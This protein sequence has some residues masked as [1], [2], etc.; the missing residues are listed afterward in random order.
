MQVPLHYLQLPR[1][2][3]IPNHTTCSP[4]T[5]PVPRAKTKNVQKYFIT[6]HNYRMR[7]TIFDAMSF[8]RRTPSYIAF[9][10]SVLLV[11]QFCPLHVYTT[12]I[13]ERTAATRDDEED[14]AVEEIAADDLII[15]CFVLVTTFQTLLYTLLG[16]D[17]SVSAS[18]T[19]TGS[20]NCVCLIEVH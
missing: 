8:M 6:M 15:F 12:A 19:V 7:L 4:P 11:Q 17:F 16:A 10:G 13:T 5:S 2:Q 14:I 18:I 1:P 20:C 9:F 3:N